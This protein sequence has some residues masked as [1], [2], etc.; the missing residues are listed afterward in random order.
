MSLASHV[1]CHSCHMSFLSRV[2]LVLC[3]SCLTSVTAFGNYFS[4]KLKTEET[5]QKTIYR[6][7][8]AIRVFTVQLM[9]ALTALSAELDKSNYRIGILTSYIIL[10]SYL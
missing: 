8:D 9:T 5:L 6:E 1:T 4:M 7:S 2:I 3:H 10:S